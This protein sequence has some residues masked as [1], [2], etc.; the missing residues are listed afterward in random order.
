MKC[1]VCGQSEA[2]VHFKEIKNDKVTELHLCRNCAQEKGFH[3]VMQS[4]KISLASQFQWMAENLSPVAEDGPGAVIC[5]GCGLRYSHFARTGR[6]GCAECYRAFQVQLQPILRR[7]HGAT[8]HAGK[9]PGLEGERLERRRQ[10]QEMHDAMEMAIQKEDFEEAARLRDRI[11]DLESEL[12]TAAEG[13]NG[14]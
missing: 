6:L 5:P 1:Q 11:R 12:K 10:L 14:S 9:A 4:D 2:S 3:S 8:R 13:G 7:V